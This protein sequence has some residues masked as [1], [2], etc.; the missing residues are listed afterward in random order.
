MHSTSILLTLIILASV[1]LYAT[2]L[3]C[4]TG[5]KFGGA[6][7]ES[8]S[9]E[10]ESDYCYNMTAEGGVLLSISK[11]NFASK[12]TFI[13]TAKFRQDAVSTDAW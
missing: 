11:A 7:G 4:Y 12:S 5:F 1:A 13:T 10:G 3:K 8:K 9:C 2:S 6:G